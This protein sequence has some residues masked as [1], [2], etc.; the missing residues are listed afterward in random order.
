[1]GSELA[2]VFWHWPRPGVSIESY[3]KRLLSFQSA[4]KSANPSLVRA[5][6]SY[7]VESLPWG[8]A[9]APL[10]EDW[11]VVKDFAAIGTL[12]DAAVV[13]GTKEFHDSVAKDYLSGAGGVF[14]LIHGSIPLPEARYANWVGKPVGTSY[15]EYYKEAT[16]ALGDQR[17]D[18]WRRQMVLG[19]SPQFCVHSVDALDLPKRFAPLTVRIEVVP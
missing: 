8:P 5:H 14:K 16:E 6:L 1:L 10:Y 17:A 7:R 19:P 13:P 11:Y 9:D 15:Q 12:N 2:Y 4:L 3:E 18:L